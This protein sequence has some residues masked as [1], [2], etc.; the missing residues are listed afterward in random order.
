MD[1]KKYFDVELKTTLVYAIAG[2]V[3]GYV[4]YTLNQTLYALFAAIAVMVGITV[5]MRYAWKI[6]EDFKWWLGN[7][8]MI[9]LFVWFIVWT[10]LYNVY[11]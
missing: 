3:M 4:S 11:V 9:Y 2:I 7:G 8:G 1:L 5:V 6:K 10:L